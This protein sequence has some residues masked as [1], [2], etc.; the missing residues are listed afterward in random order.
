M[1]NEIADAGNTTQFTYSSEEAFLLSL[2]MLRGSLRELMREG[3]VLD[4]T[5][6]VTTNSIRIDP[7]L[8]KSHDES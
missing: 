2:P 1:H 6:D 5:V 8:P 4:V 3:Y 7:R